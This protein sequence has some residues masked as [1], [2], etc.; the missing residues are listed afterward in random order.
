MHPA[1]VA[2]LVAGE[3]EDL[4]ERLQGHKDLRVKDVR[5]EAETQLFVDFTKRDR[6]YEN[7]AIPSKLLAPQGIPIQLAC[8]VPIL[9]SPSND[10][11]LTLHLNCAGFDGQP[12]AA[13]LLLPD[14]TPLPPDQWPAA[15]GPGG[16]VNGHPLFDRPFFCRAGL[17]EYHS[18]PQH[19]DDPWDRYREGT[20]IPDLVLALLFDLTHRWPGKL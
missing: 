3:V 5:L 17:R 7:A 2:E 1:D 16:I 9:G 13:N 12:P 15:Q 11:E 8:Q 18:H 19:Q 6:N 14:G 20:S 4:R 10:R